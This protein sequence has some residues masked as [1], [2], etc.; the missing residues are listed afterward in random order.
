M[1]EQLARRLR[2]GFVPLAIG[3]AVVWGLWWGYTV[4]IG[5]GLEPGQVRT[6]AMSGITAGLLVLIA[7]TFRRL[8]RTDP[9]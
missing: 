6:L 3:Y 4:V 1:N 7:W 9:E 2:R 8:D 5:G